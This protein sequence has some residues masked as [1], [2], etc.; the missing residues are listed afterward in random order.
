M[1]AGRI[2]PVEPL[3]PKKQ[4]VK[5]NTEIPTLPADKYKLEDY[6]DEYWSHWPKAKQNNKSPWLKVGLFLMLTG[7]ALSMFTIGG[8]GKTDTGG[9]WLCD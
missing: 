3:P 7:F 8:G 4:F 6:G 5:K 1:K 9:D 2:C